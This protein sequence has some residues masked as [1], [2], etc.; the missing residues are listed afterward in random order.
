MLHQTIRR[1][2]DARDNTLK[3]AHEA[4]VNAS[5]LHSASGFKCE[6]SIR[7]QFRY[8]IG[9]ANKMILQECPRNYVIKQYHVLVLMYLAYVNRI[10]KEFDYG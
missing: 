6:R 4:P 2:N 10:I 7:L 5:R 3:K 8:S 9:S 1:S